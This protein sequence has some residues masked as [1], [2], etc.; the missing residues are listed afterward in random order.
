MEFTH[1][2]PHPYT[3]H[4]HHDDSQ[5]SFYGLSPLFIRPHYYT[6]FPPSSLMLNLRRWA[7]SY[8]S[9]VR[10]ALFYE[11][12]KRQIYHRSQAA[13]ALGKAEGKAEGNVE[14]IEK[15]RITHTLTLLPYSS[16]SRQSH[17]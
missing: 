4:Y 10:E 9:Q 15:V 13:K 12:I 5:N 1:T 17:F 2:L 11:D 16:A 14:G 3:L 8:R 7:S 6:A